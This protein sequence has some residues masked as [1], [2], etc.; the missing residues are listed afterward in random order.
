VRGPEELDSAFAAMTRERAE[1]VLVLADPMTF[2]IEL[3]SQ[4]SPPSAVCPP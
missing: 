3:D 4:T 2:F 1:A